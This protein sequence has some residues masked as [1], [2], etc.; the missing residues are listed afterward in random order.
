[1]RARSPECWRHGRSKTVMTALPQS[2]SHR[3]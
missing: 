3:S 2:L 1:L